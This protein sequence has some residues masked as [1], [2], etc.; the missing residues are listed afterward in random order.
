MSVIRSIRPPVR[1]NRVPLVSAVVATALTAA[2]GLGAA[3]TA[4]ATPLGAHVTGYTSAG[5]V[6]EV[7]VYIFQE[8]PGGEYSPQWVSET[9]GGSDIASGVLP[10][11]NYVMGFFD[12]SAERWVPWTSH[13]LDGVATGSTTGNDC[14][15]SFAIDSVHGD[16]DFGQISVNEAAS[17][18]YCDIAP[19]IDESTTGTVSGQVLNDPTRDNS[20]IRVALLRADLSDTVMWWIDATLVNSDGTF[21]LYGVNDNAEYF[22]EFYPGDG[23]PYV[24]AILGATR[25][26]VLAGYTFA[27]GVYDDGF[28]ATAFTASTGHDVTLPDAHIFEGTVLA[29]GAPVVGFYVDAENTVNS[30][31]WF[32]A[33]TDA[34]GHYSVKVLPGGDY[35]LY[36]DGVGD[37]DLVVGPFVPPGYSE[38]WWDHAG[39]SGDAVA[40]DASSAGL[41]AGTFDFDVEPFPAALLGYVLDDS[42]GSAPGITAHLYQ[43]TG[44]TWTEIDQVTTDSFGIADGFVFPGAFLDG[45][46]TELDPGAYRVRFSVGAEWYGFEL[47]RAE[48]YPY[49]FYNFLAESPGCALDFPTVKP[50]P[51][52]FA[53][54]ALDLDRSL[55]TCGP[56][57]PTPAPP[58]AATSTPRKNYRA[59]IEALESTEPTA[60]PTATPT[61]SP[62]PQPSESTTAEPT[63]SAAP[64][65]A[66]TGLDF[67]FVWW[68]IGGVVFVIAAGAVYLFVIRP[69]F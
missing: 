58:A 48:S 37:A 59:A 10:D 4:Q 19:W 60:L 13:N 32:T 50:G 23:D 45:V 64:T 8:Q 20:G 41:D 65:P 9:L 6:S 36:F 17:Q 33:V 66:S 16:Y 12:D 14:G 11:G 15:I 24:E 57:T 5:L 21:T 55:I 54:V 18:D 39:V 26:D 25:T 68:S 56:E 22:L 43:A 27:G 30:D 2:L 46:T 29:D 47:G 40:L 3:S 28:A 7:I 44:S 38:Q 53:I 69:R 31:L 63:P 34:T 51:V 61:P 62:T 1:R 52:P 42:F 67:T 49:H 35:T